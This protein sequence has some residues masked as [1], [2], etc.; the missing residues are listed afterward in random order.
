MKNK[1]AIQINLY[2]FRHAV[3]MTEEK[4]TSRQKRKEKRQ[5]FPSLLLIWSPLLSLT[6]AILINDNESL[7]ERESFNRKNMKY[8][9][10]CLINSSMITEKWTPKKL[11]RVGPT[12]HNSERKGGYCGGIVL[13][14]QSILSEA[15]RAFKIR[16][17][18]KIWTNIILQL[19][20]QTKYIFIFFIME[21]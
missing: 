15:V 11:Q 12:C 6:A 5:I 10:Y 3:P 20:L 1:I 4:W 9:Q 8:L 18:K 16:R 21:V 14:P 17:S 13:L 7:D 19:F 2:S